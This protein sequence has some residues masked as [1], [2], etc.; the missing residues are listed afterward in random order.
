MQENFIY[1]LWR[2]NLLNTTNLVTTR[3]ESITVISPG[4]LNLD[5]GP[6]FFNAKIQIGETV[7][8]G[9]VEMH[10]KASN[11]RA[12]NH[13]LDDAYDNVVLHVVHEANQQIFR[14]NGEEIPTLE[15]QGKFN[16]DL[17]QRYMD[18]LK[19][20]KWI[21]CEERIGD[22]PSL[23]LSECLSRMLVE[24]LEV[25]SEL[26]INELNNSN[27]NWEEVYYVY[28]AR[29][30]GFSVNGLPFEMLAKS[31]PYKYLLKQKGNQF[32]IESM[33]YGQSG[34]LDTTFKDPY[35][36]RLVKEYDFLQMKYQLVPMMKHLWK[37]AKM[38]PSNFPTIR[39]SQFAH[40]ISR[41][42]HLFSRLLE[43][44]SLREIKK[45][46]NVM[47]S[48]YWSNNYVFDKVSNRD[49][50]KSL[51][52]ASIDNIIINTVVPFLFV[53]GIKK[54]SQLHKDRALDFLT[55]LGTEN[56]SM[57]RNMKK[58]GVNA[59]NAFD[60]QALI[61]L[62]GNYCDRK[63]CLECTIGRKLLA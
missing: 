5:S 49:I 30:F 57:I 32:R 21:A 24:K 23:T 51:G 12:H 35:P 33:L 60:T 3:G 52:T 18:F 14:K 53:Y 41:E 20:S 56:N 58:V 28:L 62:K 10:V 17:Y 47:S 40:L 36:N 19:S 11:W 43:M 27:N 46:F 34:L 6:D 9:N 39:L 22:I 13:Q 31:I 7:W 61:Y 25:K 48:D 50:Q 26:I 63:R 59:K 4:Q 54:D 15:I 37:L 42:S 2:F 38:R 16:P 1:Y 8:A 44:E 29:N 45:L 55:Q